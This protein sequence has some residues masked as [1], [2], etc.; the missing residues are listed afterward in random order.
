MEMPYFIIL[1]RWSCTLS[2]SWVQVTPVTHMAVLS[3]Y[4]I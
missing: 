1:A 3:F 4:N 2:G